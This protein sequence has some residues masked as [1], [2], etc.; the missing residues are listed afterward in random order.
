MYYKW[1]HL[2][3]VL[4]GEGR[5]YYYSNKQLIRLEQTYFIL[6]ATYLNPL[7]I[8]KLKKLLWILWYI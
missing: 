1:H 8:G 7:F 2:S 6:N 4:P 3:W 5:E